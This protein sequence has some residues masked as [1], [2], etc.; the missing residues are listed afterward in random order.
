VALSTLDAAVADWHFAPRTPCSLVFDEQSQWLVGCAAE[1]LAGFVRTG[2]RQAG[3]PIFT[4]LQSLTLDTTHVPYEQAKML[5]GQPA[6]F[7]K[8][9]D[10]GVE[11]RPLLLTQD[12]ESLARSHPGFQKDASTEEWLGIFVPR[13]PCTRTSS[14]TPRCGPSPAPS[15]GRDD[16]RAA[17]AAR[18]EPERSPRRSTQESKPPRRLRR[19]GSGRGRGEAGARGVVGASSGAPQPVLRRSPGWRA[20]RRRGAL[21]LRR[22]DGSVHRGA[23]PP[24]GAAA[25][26][27]LQGVDAR[28]TGFQ[29]WRDKPVS[30][31]PGLSGGGDRYFYAM[32][33]YL[34]FLLITSTPRGSRRCSMTRR[35]W[36]G[37]STAR[38]ATDRAV[39]GGQRG[40]ST[41]AF[42]PRRWV[43]P[44]THR[45]CGDG[46]DPLA[47]GRAPAS[48]RDRG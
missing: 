27:A 41:P 7:R 8:S 23:V 4:P 40:A 26:S 11:E 28:F 10:A 21:S 31:L 29:A 3:A 6:S 42:R 30:R 34:S 43:L 47:A 20:R 33:M 35:C 9:T 44:P 5:A 13:V 17:A 24:R 18:L 2:E 36:S 15:S 1:G 45:V 16:R 19:R 37:R 46:D 32:G 39:R 12:L 48:P 25:A 22:G 14:R 38:C